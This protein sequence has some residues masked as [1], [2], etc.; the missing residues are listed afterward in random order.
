MLLRCRET[1]RGARLRA[2]AGP[3]VP[4]LDRSRRTRVARM[5]LGEALGLEG[6]STSW[7]SFVRSRTRHH[8]L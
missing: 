1:P 3:R 8:R 7:P 5:D 2:F 4:P 6:L